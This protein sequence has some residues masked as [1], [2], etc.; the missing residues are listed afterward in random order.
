MTAAGDFRVDI[1]ATPATHVVRLCGDLDAAS[2]ALLMQSV[3][4]VEVERLELDL[5]GLTFLDAAGLG[6][7]VT[8]RKQVQASGVSVDIV[9]VQARHARLFLISGLASLI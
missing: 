4:Q 2:V 8:I 3:G 5:S 9:R 1:E 7:I 6:A